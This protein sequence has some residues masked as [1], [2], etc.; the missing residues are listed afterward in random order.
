MIEIPELKVI[1]RDFKSAIAKERQKEASRFENDKPCYVIESV[2]LQLISRGVYTYIVVMCDRTTGI[3]GVYAGNDLIGMIR[4]PNELFWQD[5]TSHY[6]S[7]AYV[8]PES[9]KYS[10]KP[11]VDKV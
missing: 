1:M 4:R 6:I 7:L 11:Y 10:I 5:M 8:S 3:V 9:E 2:Y